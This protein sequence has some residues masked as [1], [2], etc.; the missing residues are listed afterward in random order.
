MSEYVQYGEQ[1]YC[2]KPNVRV[3]RFHI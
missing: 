2:V 1:T 3:K